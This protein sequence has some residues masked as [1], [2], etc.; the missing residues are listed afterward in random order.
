MICFTFF[1][2]ALQGDC[3]EMSSHSFHTVHFEDAA[4]VTGLAT[5]KGQMLCGDGNGGLARVNVGGD[6]NVVVA[7]S[8]QASGLAFKVLTRSMLGDAQNRWIF[9]EQLSTGTNAGT[10]ANNSFKTRLLNTV[11]YNSGS[12]CTLNTSTGEITLAPGTWYVEASAPAYRVS[13][14]RSALYNVTD[15]VFVCYG[16]SEYSRGTIEASQS[17]SQ[18]SCVFNVVGSSKVFALQHR[19]DITRAQDGL[20]VSSGIALVPEIYTTIVLVRL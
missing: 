7:D 2:V 12:D 9:A 13:H 11:H 8:S 14:H 3:S 5:A 16:T 19:C 20:G 18:L 4:R 1:F 6:G 15:A 17:R 10:F